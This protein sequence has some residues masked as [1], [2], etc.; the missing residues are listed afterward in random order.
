MRVK[1]T[2]KCTPRIVYWY[3]ENQIVFFFIVSSSLLMVR[4]FYNNFPM[5]LV[6]YFFYKTLRAKKQTFP[7]VLIRGFK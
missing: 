4:C 6:A 2:I 1:M 5:F 7:L 3:R